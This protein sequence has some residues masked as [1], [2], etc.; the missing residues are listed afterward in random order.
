[1]S[2]RSRVVAVVP[3]RSGSQGLPNK[4]VLSIAGKSLLERAID[5][6]LQLELDDILVST[7][8]AQYANLASA[9]G[10]SVLGLRTPDASN[11]TAMEPD[12]IDD[13][14]HKFLEFNYT[15]PDIV[16]WIRPTFVFRS[17]RAT[18]KCLSQV[19]SGRYDSSRV[20]TQVDP[21]R[22]SIKGEVITPLFDANGASM[23]RRQ[24]MEEQASVFNIDVFKW[25]SFPCPQDFLGS[26]V[27]F[28]IAPKLCGVDI[29]SEEDFVIAEALLASLGDGNLP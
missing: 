13:L 11:A 23:V 2:N 5:F 10:A 7:D 1:M 26:E 3:A 20:V 15:P 4:N 21:R 18:K 25:P 17:I 9:A 28:A 19:E 14:N 12:V 6:G 16:V 27:G 8:S 22:Y 24:G 29:D